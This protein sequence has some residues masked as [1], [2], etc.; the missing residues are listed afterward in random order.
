[1]SCAA[2]C[3][4]S[5]GTPSSSIIIRGDVKQCSVRCSELMKVRSTVSICVLLTKYHRCSVVKLSTQDCH[6]RKSTNGLDRM[7]RRVAWVSYRRLCATAA[8]VWCAALIFLQMC[9]VAAS[10]M[11][12]G[13]R[14]RPRY[15]KAS[16]SFRVIITGG[17]VHGKRVVMVKVA[18]WR[19]AC[20]VGFS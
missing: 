8:T 19:R 3:N 13:S 2:C 17:W 12:N 1:M 15:L 14:V 11:R 18:G 16:D 7:P 20:W 4:A 5:G 9:L 10:I 6:M